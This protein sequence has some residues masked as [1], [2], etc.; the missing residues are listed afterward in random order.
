MPSSYD[1]L[2]LEVFQPVYLQRNIGRELMALTQISLRIV[3]DSIDL[4]LVVEKKSMARSASRLLNSIVKTWQ[5]CKLEHSILL[6][7][8]T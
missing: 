2:Y 6:Y 5:K 4:I 3:T 1:V 8:Y 7:L